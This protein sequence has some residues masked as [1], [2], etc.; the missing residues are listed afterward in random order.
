MEEK[1][2]FCITDEVL[3]TVTLFTH[4][5]PYYACESNSQYRDCGMRKLEKY[6]VVFRELS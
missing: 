3:V 2:P 5:A 4:L 1:M 6:C